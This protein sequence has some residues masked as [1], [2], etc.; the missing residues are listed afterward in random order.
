MALVVGA[1]VATHEYRLKARAE[2]RLADAMRAEV[3]VKLVAL[4]NELMPVAHARGAPLV[5]ESALT[6]FLSDI[7]KTGPDHVG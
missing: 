6:T 1:A 7:E 3:D 2:A 5:V 4:F